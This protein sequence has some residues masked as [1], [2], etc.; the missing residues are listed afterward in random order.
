[1]CVIEH[2]KGQ[3]KYLVSYIL[4][5]DILSLNTA[6]RNITKVAN[7]PLI[8]RRHT[9]VSQ[10]LTTNAQTLIAMEHVSHCTVLSSTNLACVCFGLHTN[11]HWRILVFIV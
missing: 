10:V 2:M 3:M 4:C 7:Q 6:A 1:M 8:T 11:I 9:N 5:L